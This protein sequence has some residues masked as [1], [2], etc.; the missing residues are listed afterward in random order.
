[1]I[2]VPLARAL[3]DAGLRWKPLP[4]DRFIVVDK[5][6]DDEIFVLSHLTIEVHD[7]P[8]GPIIKFNGSTEW[9][10]DSLDLDEAL[11]LP[12]EEQ[13]RSA[14][15]GTF[16]SL[17]HHNGVHRVETAPGSQEA[18]RKVFDHADATDAYAMALLE[19]L[20]RIA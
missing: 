1:M 12:S 14:L 17:T 19:L 13:L 20:K 18:D 9:A 10:L 6:M 7:H 4:G 3:R 5:D 2:S 8:A 15:G 11:W 16:R